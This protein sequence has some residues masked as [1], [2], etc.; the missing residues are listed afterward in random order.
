MSAR[1]RVA[2][3]VTALAAGSAF[4]VAT[5]GAIATDLRTSSA[6][7]Q[8]GKF[9]ATI[10]RE[11]LARQF[12]VAWETLYPP[13]QLVATREAY[14]ACESLIPWSGTVAAVH[15]VRVFPERIRIAG[16]PRKVP[17][18]AVS[19]R[20]TVVAASLPIPVVIERT[21]HAIRVRAHWTWILSPEQYANY[22]ARTCPY[23]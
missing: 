10:A 9:M 18:E 11:K 16:A 6:G 14:V 23:A 17:T 1:T 13:H 8:V 20:I 3:T 2:I 5:P 22:S 19:M 12:D 21:F 7:E 4:F 15:I